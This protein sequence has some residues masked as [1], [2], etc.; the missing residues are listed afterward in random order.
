MSIQYPIGSLQYVNRPLSSGNRSHTSTLTTDGDSLALSQLSCVFIVISFMPFLPE[1]PRYLANQGKNEQAAYNLAALRGNL[2][3]TPAIMEEL[4]EIQY[5]IAVENS[6]GWL[7]VGCLQ[8]S[9]HLW[10]H[11]RP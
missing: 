7:L 4:K 2:P 5:A 1:S 3:D 8:G 10:V 11:P 9:R 6:R